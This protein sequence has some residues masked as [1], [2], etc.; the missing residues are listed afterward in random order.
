VLL[1]DPQKAWR[2]QTL[3]EEAA[4]SH[5]QVS[6]VKRLLEDREW[7]KGSDTGLLLGDPESLLSEWSKNFNTRKTA[8]RNYCTPKGI[9]E[10]E[11]DLAR[12]CEA[13][14][15]AYALTGFSGAA[16]YAPAVRYQRVMA[17]V[18]PDVEK[19]A[20]SLS[21]KEV[22]S[23]A[24]VTLYVPSDEGVLYGARPIDGVCV[25]S[26]V[27]VYLD[28]FGVKGRGEEA[29]KALLEKVIRRSW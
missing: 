13:K 27:Q 12:A 28:L 16:R 15:I 5:G 26:P 1:T 14:G 24:N 8:S 17:Y 18:L 9:A 22:A 20:E 7:L 25:A 3:A 23:G 29:P 10:I 6:D 4:I 21:L 11:A 19:I 2:V